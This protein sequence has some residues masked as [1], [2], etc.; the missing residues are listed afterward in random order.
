MST[1]RNAAPES[2][3]STLEQ[4]RLSGNTFATKEEA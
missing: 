3:F 2:I 1:T 4:E